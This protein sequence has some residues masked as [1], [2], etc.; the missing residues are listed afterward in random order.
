MKVKD[1]KMQLKNEHLDIPNV[2]DNIK[3]V[4]YNAE[5][6]PKTKQSYFKLNTFLKYSISFCLFIIL[7]VILIPN[8]SNPGAQMPES[9]SPDTPSSEIEGNLESPEN[10]ES[11]KLDNLSKQEIDI[12]TSY[13]ANNYSSTIEL[14]ENFNVAGN[15]LLKATIHN[16]DIIILNYEIFNYIRLSISKNNNIS[17]DECLNDIYINYG[18]SEQYYETISNAYTFIIEKDQ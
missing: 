10:S 3:N 1:F 16:Q 13:L 9:A 2:L 7:G 15:V 18:L 8:L 6:K 5:F 4:A 14:F 11:F 17:L 12:Y